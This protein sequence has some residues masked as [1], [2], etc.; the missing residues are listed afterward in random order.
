MLSMP[1]ATI[2]SAM[3]RASMSCAKIA[4]CMPDPQTLLTVIASAELRKAGADRRLARRSLAEAGREHVAH[5]DLV[6]LLAADPGPLDRGLDRGRAELGR[7]ERRQ[8]RP[9]S[10]PSACAR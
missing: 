1:P 10:C 2:T 4:A 5:E 8:A 3:P 7:G 9:G 6:D